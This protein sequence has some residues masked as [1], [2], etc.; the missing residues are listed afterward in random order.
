MF[1]LNGKTALIT[2]SGRGIG[3]AIAE[4]MAHQGANI[5]LSD[6]N[7]SVVERAAGELAGKYPNVAVR[8]LTFDVTDKAQ[9]ESA[10]QTIKDAGNGLQILV[11]N[12]AS[13]CGN[14]WRTWTT[15]WAEDARHE[16]TSVFRVSRAAFPMLKEKGGKVIN[17]CS[18]MSEIARPTVSPYAS[19]KG[20]V[21]QFT[22]ALATEWAEHNIQVNGIAPGFIATDMNIPLMEDKDLNDYI[23]RHT[24]AKRWGKPSEVASVAAFLASPAADFVNGQVIFIDG[25]FI[26]SL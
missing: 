17:L 16:L 6:I 7:S 13:A 24:P 19:T 15:P 20:A 12:A 23:M 25:G 10:I 11:N 21:R 2:G 9:I 22:R 8:G 4:A 1:S 18:L 3:L 26:I 5:F 14:P